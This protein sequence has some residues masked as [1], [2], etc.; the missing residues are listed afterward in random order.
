[1]TAKLKYSA[2]LSNHY[3]DSEAETDSIALS[4]LEYY[5]INIVSDS[6]HITHKNKKV[7]VRENL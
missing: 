3:S 4:I 2:V 7:E 5:C 1:M 6:P